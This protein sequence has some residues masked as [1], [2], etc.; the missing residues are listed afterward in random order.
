VAVLAMDFDDFKAINDTHGH[1]CGDRAL[2]AFAQALRTS[3]RASDVPARPGGDEFVV[4]LPDSGLD[5]AVLVADRVRDIV[6]RLRIEHDGK[7]VPISVSFGVSAVAFEQVHT[8]E[9]ALR[10]AD[11][12]LLAAKRAGRAQIWARRPDELRAQPA[13]VV[14][15]ERKPADDAGADE[16]Q[17]G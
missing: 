5:D 7:L 8:V 12:A 3:L 2:A 4:M 15:R 1:E 13:R 10:A 6:S 9:D 16:A 14:R 17:V 11:D